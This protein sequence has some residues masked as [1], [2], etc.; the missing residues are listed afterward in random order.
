MVGSK[1]IYII[2]N[3]FK[4]ESGEIKDIK[5]VDLTVSFF[6]II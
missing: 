3:L 1:N 4:K 6:S 2:N 5:D